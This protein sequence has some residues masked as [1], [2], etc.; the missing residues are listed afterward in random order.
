[1]LHW[2]AGE[3]FGQPSLN[4][5]MQEQSDR[6]WAT[7]TR[8]PIEQVRE[9]R[10]AAG[11]SD[12]SAPPIKGLDTTML[13]KRDQVLVVAPG[14]QAC[15]S[16]LQRNANGYTQVWAPAEVPRSKG[17]NEAIGGGGRICGQFS[18]ARFDQDGLV[19]IEMPVNNYPFQ[20]SVPVRTYRYRWDGHT[21]NLIEE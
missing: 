11:V 18:S 7:V 10:I 6:H 21:Y 16:V 19:V 5:A 15:L 3:V 17:N 14:H 12:D 4:S 9:I 8:L 13:S 2:F 20:R 1:M